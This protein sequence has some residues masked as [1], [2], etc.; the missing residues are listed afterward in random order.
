[1]N[2]SKKWLFVGLVVALFVACGGNPSGDDLGDRLEPLGDIVAPDYSVLEP[3]P[4][5]SAPL[6][7]ASEAKVAASIKNGIRLQLL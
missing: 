6:Q 2:P 5:T 1:M 4:V 7:L 3:I